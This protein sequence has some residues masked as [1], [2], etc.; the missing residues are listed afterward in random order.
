MLSG[1]TDGVKAFVPY[2]EQIGL[3]VEDAQERV[4]KL[5]L[6]EKIRGLLPITFVGEMLGA[7]FESVN[8]LRI[9]IQNVMLDAAIA[10]KNAAA[11][12][13]GI[14]VLLFHV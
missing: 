2:H 1:I 12:A 5:V 7:A 6:Y 4:G 9:A 13:I 11:K 10:T 8:N 14:L 3:M